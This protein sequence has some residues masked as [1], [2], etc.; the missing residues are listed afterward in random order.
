MTRLTKAL[1]T[2]RDSTWAKSL[3]AAF[4]VCAAAI[5]AIMVYTVNDELSQAQSMQEALN[6]NNLQLLQGGLGETDTEPVSRDQVASTPFIAVDQ[7]G[8]YVSGEVVEDIDPKTLE[9]SFAINPLNGRKST[10]VLG[11]HV[12]M[13]SGT[14]AVH[15]APG[16][17]EDDYKVGL[18]Y[19]LD[20]IMQFFM[21]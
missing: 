6:Q 8:N 3:A 14:G 18:K 1:L 13:D 9:N 12:L 16:H 4:V 5:P 17:G 21:Q 2:P 15:T 19:G 10:I 11:D 7:D 20:V